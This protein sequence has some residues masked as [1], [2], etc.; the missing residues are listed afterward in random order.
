MSAAEIANELHAVET[1]AYEL[2][3]LFDTV[4]EMADGD[5]P[6]HLCGVGM[7]GAREVIRLAEKVCDIAGRVKEL[8]PVPYRPTAKAK[9]KA[10]R[11]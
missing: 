2:A 4:S 5:N 6:M 9:K 7:V 11:R 3:D 10:V 1:L 8:A